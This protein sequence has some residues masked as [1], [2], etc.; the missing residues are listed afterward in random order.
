VVVIAAGWL[1]VRER[2]REV[3]I[4]AAAGFL[5]SLP[6]PLIFKV[7]VRD[8]LAYVMNDYRIP[9]DTEWSSILSG[10]PSQMTDLITNNLAYPGISPVPTPLTF[11]IGALVIAALI[12]LF[13][14]WSHRDPFVSLMRATAVGGVLTILISINYTALRL[15]LVFVP[16]AA[17]GLALLAERYLPRVRA[18][19]APESAPAAQ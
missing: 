6:A 17:T 7:P 8:N 16:A 9:S 5:V 11:V 4:A 10:Y 2:S 15:E 18:P 13:V 19:A 1:A 12:A 14:P 3:G